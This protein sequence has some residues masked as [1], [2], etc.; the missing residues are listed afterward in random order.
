MK[1]LL[2]NARVYIKGKFE[3]V[4]VLVDRGIIADI[5]SNDAEISG[6]TVFDFKNSYIF[7]GLI[8]VHVHLREP[9][10]CYKE[11][12]SSGTR[13]AARGGYTTVCSMPNLKPVPDCIENLTPQLDIIKRDAVIN[14]VPY[15]SLS[16]GQKGGELSD[17]E[18]MKDD[19]VAFSDDGRGLQSASLMAQAMQRAKV[20]SKTVVAHCEDN[21]LL[22]GGYIHDGEYCAAHSHKGICSES[23][24]G[25]V[26][27][28][29]ELCRLTGCSYH[30]CH[31][32]AKETVE[33][34]R[35]AKKQGVDV[36]CETAPH[37]LCLCDKDLK[38]DGRFKMNPPLRGED[39][40]NALIKGILDG[41][42][43]MIATDH[44]PHSA[45][46]KSRGLKD[47]LMGVVGLETA[48]PV[49]YTNLVRTGVISL[50]KLIELMHDNPSKRF[51]LGADIEIGAPADLAVF[52]FEKEY[53]IN[54]QEFLSMG[55]AT[56]FEGMQ[57]YGRCLMTVCGG[58][59]V[60]QEDE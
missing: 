39:D 25:P 7:P 59:I 46:E 23:E 31:V 24:W 11:T 21:S 58:K 49:L 4:S 9:G 1:F 5:I 20:L 28:D 41:T 32:S 30:V 40:K 42:V 57:V 37:Y 53:M 26:E 3:S 45:E 51:S 12:I 27:R 2:K 38:E 55:K 29:L 48:V 10:F 6:V 52:N 36:T 47:S 44:A 54:P 33:L 34:I 60:W 16:V 22:H 43:D 17:M 13:A 8:D 19:T 56:P 15:G 35:Y 50:E 18:S 14:V